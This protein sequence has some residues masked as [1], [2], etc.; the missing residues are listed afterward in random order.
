MTAYANEQMITAIREQMRAI[1]TEQ[2]KLQASIDAGAE[3]TVDMVRRSVNIGGQW[4][5][6][7][8]VLSMLGV[9]DQTMISWADEYK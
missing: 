6:Y 3:L 1:R 5:A 9:D 7:E 4:L 2:N 8:N